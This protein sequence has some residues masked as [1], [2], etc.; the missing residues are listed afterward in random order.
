MRVG[1]R[2]LTVILL[3]ALSSLSLPR[4]VWSQEDADPIERGEYLTRAGLCIACHT[5]LKN[6]GV[7]LAG[8][9]PI[10]TPF[11]TIYSTNIT[12]D[13]ETGIGDW[14]DADFLRAMRHGIGRQG[15]HLYPAFPY[16]SYTNM[17]EEDMLAIKAYLFSI[18]PVRQQN[19]P[20]E[21]SPPFSWRFLLTA[22][23]WMYLKT[24]PFKPDA[25]KSSQWNRGAYLVEGVVHCGECHTPRDIAGGLDEDFYM[26]GAIDGPEGELAPNITA[27]PETGL[28]DWSVDDT[29]YLL[30]EGYKPGGDNVQGLM[31][32][33]IVHGY[34][35]M[36]DED[37]TAVATYIRSLPPVDNLVE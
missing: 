35:Y 7:A 23:K 31:E 27:H 37:L 32:E 28:G 19:K 8:G 30:K 24:G 36:T 29:V 3:V 2:L 33:I 20:P 16:T 5:D 10:K 6:D 9:N 22:W 11:G 18:D 4:F 1:A 12:P 14:S 21:M 13:R 17:T 15:Q 25:Q 26:A 34:K